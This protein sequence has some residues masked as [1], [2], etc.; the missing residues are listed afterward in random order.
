VTTV[1][2]TD[3]AGVNADRY[4]FRSYTLSAEPGPCRRHSAD[5]RSFVVVSGR[6][7]VEL[8]GRLPVEYG[9]LT[10]FHAGPGAVYR[11]RS[12]S[13]EPAVVLEA[14][15]PLGP[16]SVAAAT[17][18]VADLL[19]LADHRVTKPW[20]FEVW[21]TDN[22]PDPPYALKQIHMTAGHRSSLQSHD[23]KAETNLVVD[24][25]ATVLN[26]GTAPDDPAVGVDPG[27]LPRSVH[28]PGSGWSSPPRMLHRV[29]AE[30]D[31]TAIEVSTPELD[32]VTRWQDDAG[33]GSGRIESEHGT[34]R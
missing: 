27:A 32:D 26:G 12:V 18:L 10:G 9:L 25:E 5:T 33:R 15:S 23:R 22:L 29:I 8:P 34:P 13:P 19:P 4:L 20:G 21:Y 16:T 14:G 31:Y 6:I 30:R 1:D 17:T 24:G 11:L 7:A 2:G 28:G 3:L